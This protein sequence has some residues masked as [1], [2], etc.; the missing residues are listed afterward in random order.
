MPVAT[1]YSSEDQTNKNNENNSAKVQK[2]QPVLVSTSSFKIPDL[3][4]FKS[5]SFMAASEPNLSLTKNEADAVNAIINDGRGAS[6]SSGYN[7]GN[8]QKTD[9]QLVRP[10]SRTLLGN[11][12][13]SSKP[14]TAC[15]H[16]AGQELCYLCHQRQRRNNPV[17]LH[18]E[19]KIK[20]QEET[21]IL[22]QYQQLKDLEKQLQDEAKRNAQ[23]LDRAKMDAFNL[24]VSEAIKAKRK[25]RPKTSDMSVKKFGKTFILLII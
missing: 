8:R 18:E 21:Q 19:N 1:I 11:L 22:M 2:S 6:G 10:S 4:N 16:H 14:S 5:N 24:G 13:P 20:D 15:G 17:Y 25:E 7:L 23:R 12:V 3:L 9:V